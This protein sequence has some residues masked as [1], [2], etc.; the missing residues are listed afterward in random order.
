MPLLAEYPDFSAVIF[1]DPVADTQAEAGTGT[2]RLGRIEGVHDLRQ[3][4]RCNT[5]PPVEK[6]QAYKLP[7]RG[8]A[9]FRFDVKGFFLIHGGIF[10]IQSVTGIADKI[11]YH[12]L[13]LLQMGEHRRQIRGHIDQQF[14]TVPVK[15]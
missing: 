11:K 3:Y 4:L 15:L 14:D 1:N 2:T 10:L 6:G 9:N 7:P 8:G 13:N 5:N 12:L